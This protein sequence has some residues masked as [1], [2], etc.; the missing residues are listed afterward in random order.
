M[1]ILDLKKA[2]KRQIEDHYIRILKLWKAVIRQGFKDKDEKFIYSEYCKTLCKIC[3]LNYIR[4][5]EQY[6][7]ML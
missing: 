2:S 5:V 4:L 6:E 1:K 3:N 7:E